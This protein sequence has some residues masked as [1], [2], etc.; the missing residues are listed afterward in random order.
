MFLIIEFFPSERIDVELKNKA[1][2]CL[3]SQVRN[4]RSPEFV[5]ELAKV[6]GRQSQLKYAEAFEIIRWID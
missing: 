6:R 5:E 2:R 3:D 1:Y 4:F